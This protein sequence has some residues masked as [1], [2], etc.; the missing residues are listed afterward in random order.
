MGGVRPPQRRNN[1]EPVRPGGVNP[2]G[3]PRRGNGAPRLPLPRSRPLGGPWG[4]PGA[5]LT[6]RAAMPTPAPTRAAP[7]LR[8]ARGPGPSPAGGPDPR[9]SPAPCPAARAARV[10]EAARGVPEAR[11]RSR[12][13]AG[14]R[15]DPRTSLCVWLLRAAAAAAAA[16]AAGPGHSCL[17]RW[18]RSGSAAPA[19]IKQAM[20]SPAAHAPHSSPPVPRPHRPPPPARAHPPALRAPSPPL[21][22]SG[23]RGPDAG[24]WKPG[25][26]PPAPPPGASSDA[27]GA[28][29]GVSLSQ[30]VGGPGA[31]AERGS[32]PEMGGARSDWSYME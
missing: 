18:E 32:C 8:A 4:A 7:A 11:R 31:W 20:A 16:A 15:G 2:R 29:R 14:G 26:S 23:G 9:G 24:P 27:G 21:G 19:T 28:A 13:A 22:P 30:V 12:G 10:A 17:S 5:D 1:N 25:P 3:P 6:V